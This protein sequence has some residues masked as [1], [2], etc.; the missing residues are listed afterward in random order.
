MFLKKKKKLCKP[1][2]HY[3][4]PVDEKTEA[5]GPEFLPLSVVVPFRHIIEKLN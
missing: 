2:R 1:L 4:H 5:R 3:L